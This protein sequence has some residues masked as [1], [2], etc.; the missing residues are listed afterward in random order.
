MILIAFIVLFSGIYASKQ[1]IDGAFKRTDIYQ[2]KPMPLPM[3]READV[4][5][6]S[7]VWRIIDLREKMNQPLYYPTVPVDK[8][9]NLITVLLEGI[10]KGQITPWDARNDND[11]FK[12]PLTYDQ[13]KESFGAK[14]KTQQFV[15]IDTG[16]TKDTVVQQEMRPTEVKQ[17]MVK[18]EWYF[19]KSNSELKVRVIGICPIR[20]FVRDGD[21]SG[22]IQRQK[23]FWIYFPE[24]REL[25]STSLVLNPDNTARQ[26]SFDDLFIKRYFNSY[27]VKESNVFN[28]EISS[29]V[30]G[31]NAMLESKKLEDKIF[32]FEQDL[33][34]Y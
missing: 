34:E 9:K 18:E 27:V 4:F 11:E 29:Y 28:R 16:E 20:E 23:V 26:M 10:E 6:S 24:A 19:D 31:K 1:V 25:L 32:N 3:V 2:K 13:V 30:S 7:K 33:W 8:M 21:I 12:S 17:Y 22:Q 14:A 15:D 5:W